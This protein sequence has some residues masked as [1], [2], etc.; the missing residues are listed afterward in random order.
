MIILDLKL[1]EK[2]W[3]PYLPEEINELF[4]SLT[5]PWWI[6]G[7][8]AIELFL[9]TKTRKHLDIDIQIL[10]K[11]Q[12]I[13][14]E[15]LESWDLYKTNQ[16]GLKPWKKDEFLQLGVNC[17][18]CRK[19]HEAPWKMEIMF[20]DSEGEEWIYRRKPSIRGLFSEIGMK[21]KSGIPYLSPE[22]QL[23]FKAQRKPVLKDQQDFDNVLK[24]LDENKLLWLKEALLKQLSR[25]HIWIQE[26]NNIL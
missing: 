24:I 26:I 1:D 8:W 17:V 23:L 25:N 6:A 12:L 20:L 22:I 15:F 19:T 21:T 18:W 3:D 14:Q 7:G 11:D 9:G 5:I 13:L 16:P 4:K 2:N 10:R